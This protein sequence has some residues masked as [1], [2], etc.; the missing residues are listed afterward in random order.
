[1]LSTK[2]VYG[3][4]GFANKKCK[5]WNATTFIEI[6]ISHSSS[7]YFKKNS[8]CPNK[9]FVFGIPYIQ[10]FVYIHHF[11]SSSLAHLRI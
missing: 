11:W 7:V 6:V 8:I 3:S 10:L 4:V 1:M 2:D 9:D 5:I